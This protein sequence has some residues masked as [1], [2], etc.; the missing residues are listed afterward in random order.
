MKKGKAFL[1][2]LFCTENGSPIHTFRAMHFM[3]H[4]ATGAACIVQWLGIAIETVQ[5]TET[6]APP[7]ATVQKKSAT[8]AK[9]KSAEHI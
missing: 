5:G 8:M 4:E 3:F 2:A 1:L 9:E 7:A 6:A